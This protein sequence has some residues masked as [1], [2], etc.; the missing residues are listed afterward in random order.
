MAN[1]GLSPGTFSSYGAFCAWYL[2]N[3][4]L[5]EAKGVAATQLGERQLWGV[6][7]RPACRNPRC[8]LGIQL[9]KGRSCLNTRPQLQEVQSPGWSQ[10]PQPHQKW[11]MV[12]DTRNAKIPSS[13]L[14]HSHR[15]TSELSWLGILL[16]ATFKRPLERVL[17]V[18]MRHSGTSGTCL[19]QSNPL[20]STSTLRKAVFSN[21]K[22]SSWTASSA[23]PTSVLAVAREYQEVFGMRCLT[24]IW[25]LWDIIRTLSPRGWCFNG[26]MKQE[27]PT[28]TYTV[29]I[30]FRLLFEP[31]L[32]IQP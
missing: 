17:L 21:T 23:I 22:S 19:L 1:S 30:V 3:C 18:S 15:V 32:Y 26:L 8:Q 6:H 14:S 7:G 5:Q 12:P 29:H 25:K 20:S 27:V 2:T 31:R 4:H 9:L 13:G 11:R 24:T 10:V 28:G 16:K